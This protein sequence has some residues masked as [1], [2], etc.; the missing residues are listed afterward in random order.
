MRFEG[1]TAVVSGGASGLGRAVVERVAACG[2]KAVVLDVQ[3]EAGRELARRHGAAVRFVTTDVR[4]EAAVERGLEEA[5]DFFG[6]PPALAVSCAGVLGAGRVLAR[7]GPMPSARFRHVL[8]VNLLGT[9][10]LVRASAARM[11]AAEPNEEGERGLVVLTASVA[12]FE[13]QIGQAA[14]SASKGG[15][16][17]M[18]LPL[19]REFARIGV[20]VV[21][22][23]PGLFETPMMEG[24]TPEVRASLSAQVPFPARL[25]RPDEYA[26]FVESIVTTPLLNGCTLRLDGAIRLQPK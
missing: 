8:E 2:G 1:L 25:G 24:M 5:A 19:A 6:R 23:A 16:A 10:H 12:A 21:T 17:S 20:R 9:F 4:D 11:A 7:E 26:A 15:V 14:Y 22:I 13:G 3:E 18:T